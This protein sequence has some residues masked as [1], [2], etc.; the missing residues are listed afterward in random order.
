MK[1][2]TIDD[3][4]YYHMRFPDDMKGVT[5]I[6]SAV[7]P[8]STRQGK[9]GPYSGNPAVRARKGMAEVTAWA[10]AA[11]RRQPGLRLHRRPLALELGQRQLPHGRAQRHRLGGRSRFR[12][13]AFPR[14]G[15]RSRNS[16]PTSTSRSRPTS[17][18]RRS[19]NYSQIS[20]PGG[21]SLAPVRVQERVL[22]RL[23][24]AELV[25]HLRSEGRGFPGSHAFRSL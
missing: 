11:A 10:L 7:P 23:R 18:R 2:F 24:G 3:E 5:P 21:T 20:R 4:W 15:P 9:D 17:T 19:E 22:Q 25:L 14:S 16:K 13:A 6:L 1:P 12:P 8:E